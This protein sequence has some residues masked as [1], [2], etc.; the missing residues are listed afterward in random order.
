[1]WEVSWTRFNE[2]KTEWSMIQQSSVQKLCI[3]IPLVINVDHSILQANEA[4]GNLKSDLNRFQK[5]YEAMTKLLM[6]MKEQLN[7]QFRLQTNEK[8]TEEETTNN[9]ANLTDS[10]PTGLQLPPLQHIDLLEEYVAMFEKEFILKKTV[11]DA[12]RSYLFASLSDSKAVVDV[13]PCPRKSELPMILTSYQTAWEYQPG[14]NVKL[15]NEI[16]GKL[17]LNKIAQGRSRM[18]QRKRGLPFRAVIRFKNKT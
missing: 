16:D 3:M 14:L 13:V 8:E 17:A 11:V 18:G 7:L 5:I 2:R 6:E 15:M 12:I 1:M 4:Y 10:G 9:F